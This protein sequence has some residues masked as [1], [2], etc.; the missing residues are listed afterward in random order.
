MTR[1]TLTVP[2]TLNDGAA[3]PAEVF[4]YVETQLGRHAGGYSFT[5][6]VGC[7]RSPDGVTYR[8]PIRVFTID[9]HETLHSVLTFLA[10]EIAFQLDQEAVYVTAAL[11]EARLVRPFAPGTP[12]REAYSIRVDPGYEIQEQRERA[13][14]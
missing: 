2:L 12:A 8:E 13:G 3:S 4:E 1:F 6:S 14:L 5:D 10:E 7:W 9:G 11:V